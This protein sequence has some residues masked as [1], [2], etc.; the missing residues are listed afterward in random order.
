[1]YIFRIVNGDNQDTYD[2]L[3]TGDYGYNNN[4]ID[5]SLLQTLILAVL[6]NIMY[7]RQGFRT[8]FCAF[9][10]GCTIGSIFANNDDME[11]PNP[12]TTESSAQSF[13]A[14]NAN[15]VY[16]KEKKS[17]ISS[18]Q[19]L[20]SSSMGDLVLDQEG[21]LVFLLEPSAHS[22]TEQQAIYAA[23]AMMSHLTDNQLAD[24]EDQLTGEGSVMYKQNKDE[25][26]FPPSYKDYMDGTNVVINATKVEKLNNDTL[27]RERREII[28]DA[29][30]HTWS[31]Y[32]KYA[33]G[34]DELKPVKKEGRNNYGGMGTTLVDSLDTLWLMG[35]YDEFWEARDWVRDE[36][37]HDAV[38]DI[39]VFETTI[40][41]LGGL[42]AAYDWSGDEV[43]LEKADDLGSRLVR[44]FDSPSGIPYGNTALNRNHSYNTAW[45]GES[46]IL[47]ELGTL[48]LEFRHLA[49]ATGKQH[50]ADKAN[51]VF[52]VMKTIEPDHG[53]Y[54]IFVKN[55]GKEP[56][57]SYD[58]ISFGAMGDSFYEY[59]LKVWIQ[60]GKAESMYRDMWDRSMDGLHKYLLQ[61]S[62]PS[63]LYYLADLVD[64]KLDH[65]M[66]HLACFMGGAL[67][68]GAY[69]DPNGLDSPRAKRDL[70]TGKALA[71]TC[72]QMYTRTLTGISPEFV[73][74]SKGEDIGIGSATHN[75]LRPEAVETFFVLYQL[76]GDYTYREWGWEIFQAFEK[77]SRTSAG[78][79]SIP[80]VNSVFREP[81]DQ[82]ESF[83][84]AETLK[85][86]YLLQDPDTPIDILD[87]H[88]FNTE[89]HPLRMF[90]LLDKDIERE[91]RACSAGKSVLSSEPTPCPAKV[92][93]S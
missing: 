43:F 45:T 62:T 58:K 46:S 71:Y 4:Y 68:L 87:K 31:G 30:K 7:Q 85:Y 49:K 50:Y 48:Q 83:F 69:T 79:A 51:K 86:L 42:L 3:R 72:Y 77:H 5:T 57:F 12:T 25:M 35:M 39:S 90:P 78:Y 10:I 63:G 32:R 66:D 55:Q 29:M 75:M 73:I 44:A 8:A 9:L 40:R 84:I 21:K 28:R 92:L 80:N 11:F 41:S 74:F 53:L 60:G 26:T 61:K 65:K 56:I 15:T 6:L 16:D 54:P 89:A 64:K 37:D 24:L 67:A 19:K 14:K 23:R 1:M 81:K 91:L 52:E 2:F 36:L 13:S 59:L 33:W 34:K 20:V 38:A 88:V 22:M 76:T 82:M 18:G 47:A 93:S 17:I 27:A 70:Q